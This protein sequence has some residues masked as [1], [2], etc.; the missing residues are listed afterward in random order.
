MA[1]PDSDTGG[2][3]DRA[4]VMHGD[5]I[6]LKAAASPVVAEQVRNRAEVFSLLFYIRYALNRSM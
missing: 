4:A 1:F 6:R 5:P 3:R 2:R